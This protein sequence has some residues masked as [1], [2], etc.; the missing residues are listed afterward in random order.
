MLNPIEKFKRSILHL[1]RSLH[2]WYDYDGVCFAI[3]S[4]PAFD[5]KGLRFKFEVIGRFNESDIRKGVKSFVVTGTLQKLASHINVYIWKEII[6]FQDT[7]TSLLSYNFP[8]SYISLT[9]LSWKI[10]HIDSS[11]KEGY[12]DFIKESD[13]TPYVERPIAGWKNIW[14]NFITV[15]AVVF[16]RITFWRQSSYYKALI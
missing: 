4:W 11:P 3:N 8:I 14:S 9:A 5:C 6:L 16:L 1:N 15:F 13:W 10:S 2:H 12:I 7:P